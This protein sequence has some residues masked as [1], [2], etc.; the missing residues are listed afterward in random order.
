MA[1]SPRVFTIPPSA[2]FLPTLV[3][4]L[5]AGEIVPGFPPS[6]DPLALT[7]ATIYLPTRRACRLARDA[8]LH[9]LGRSA[10]LLPRIV[11]LGD[12]D[13]DEFA[14]AESS[15]P[16]AAALDLPKALDPL[17]R[18]LLLARLISTWAASPEVRGE[19]GAPLVA[20]NPAAALVLAD[21]LARLIDDMV[22]RQVDWKR[23]DDLVPVQFDEYWQLTLRFLKIARDR[24]PE[25]LKDRGAMEPAERRDR[26]IAA[27]A[28]RLAANPDAPV[29]AAGSTGSMPATAAFL[30]RIARLPHGAVVLPGLD[31]ELADSAWNLIVG[32]RDGKRDIAPAQTHPQFAMQA[33][34]GRMG[35]DRRDVPSLGIPAAHGREKLVS[36]ALCP[37]AASECWLTRL[38]DATIATALA[39][40]AVIEAASSEEEA[41][42][43]AVVLREALADNKSAALV[44]PDRALA[45]RVAAALAR[46]NVAVE[47][48]AGTPLT[49]SP[50]GVFA[51]LAARAAL[52]ALE[53]VTLLAL[54]KH[55]CTRL[56]A[57]TPMHLRAVNGL[58]RAVLRGARPRAGAAGLRDALVSFRAN[59]SSLHKSDPRRYIGDR[60]LDAAER[61]VAQLTAALAPLH[62]LGNHPCALADLARRH[63]AV[64]GAL[65]GGETFLAGQ[66]GE[67][68]L[69]ALDDFAEFGED[70][71][72]APADYPDLFALLAADR[73]IRRHAAAHARLH[74]FGLLEARLASVDRVV[75]GGLSEGVWPPDARNDAWLSRPMRQDIGLDLPERRIGLT[76]HD[77]AQSLGA[78]EVVLA[79]AAKVGGTPTLWSRFV[80]RLAAVAGE[81]QWKAAVARGEQYLA[82]ARALDAPDEVKPI[83]RPAPRP[84]REVRP[85]RL[86]V[87]EIEH[88]LRDPYT[89]YAKHILRLSPLD[90]V[91]EPPAYR[92]RGS[93]IHEAIGE[94]TETFADQLP[95][96]PAAELIAIGRRHF[97]RLAEVPEARAFW[98]PRFERIARWFADWEKERRGSVATLLAEISGE[99][100]F[101]LGDRV[102]RLRARADRIEQ[103]SDGRYAVLDYKTGQTPTA[104]QVHSGL[105]PQLTLE[106]AILR[107]GGFAAVP[108]G[109]SVAAFAYV[110][111]RGGEPAGEERPIV[112]KDSDPDF[113][114]DRAL[115]RLTAV[116]ARFE[117][118]ETPYCSLVRPMWVGRRYGDYDH[119]ARVKE[120]AL[121]GGED[122]SDW[123]PPP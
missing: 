119:L 48:S 5:A 90:A 16:A 69:R 101:P 43:I 28:A 104:P 23:L 36:E 110:A 106:A 83:A 66:E 88:W 40:V 113:E 26:L 29:I 123:A 94:F 71:L 111:L 18:R 118:A 74:I 55:P 30:T 22:T 67:A 15:G 31:R 39:D 19:A 93:V 98:W 62:E 38:P 77:F 9:T 51:R 122:E 99:I 33:L 50:A 2:P 21:D 109:A 60:E 120:W 52:A 37:A 11:A 108:A 32:K 103:L 121:N 27:E 8:F 80:Q 102:F 78:R 112:W 58:E 91:D 49:E 3:T 68:L 7:R 54:L 45:R 70:F 85:T 17:E 84:P 116:A 79:R 115:S 44:T 89:I 117:D 24:W 57:D 75:L 61:L 10:A 73:V 105:A 1:E 87:T 6:A 4:A 97:A 13:E 42:A 25:I 63:R 92:D 100:D 64:I 95:A 114:A 86:S 41:L 56:D 12:I 76:A 53:P 81:P 20:A 35:I 107:Q 82:W 72:V 96:D 34:L 47:D 14:F 46:W 59:R 65:A